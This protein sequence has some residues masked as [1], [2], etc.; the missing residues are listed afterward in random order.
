VR[1]AA[2][3]PQTE[4]LS[5]PIINQGLLRF[6][7]PNSPEDESL[8]DRFTEQVIAAINASGEAFFQPSTFKGKRCMRV[9]V[10]NWRTNEEDVRRTLNAIAKA[11]EEVRS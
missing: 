10:S 7:D 2:Q 6:L 3:L 4:V 5:F 8:N 1:G 11:I 9:S